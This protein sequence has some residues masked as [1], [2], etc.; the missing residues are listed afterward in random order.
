MDLPRPCLRVVLSPLL[1]KVQESSGYPE[2]YLRPSPW[3]LAHHWREP[4]HTLFLVPGR[5]LAF[6][7]E[8]LHL[9]GTCTVLCPSFSLQLAALRSGTNPQT[10]QAPAPVLD[11]HPFVFLFCKASAGGKRVKGGGPVM[12]LWGMLGN[13]GPR[14]NHLHLILGPACTS[15]RA[16][17]ESS[18][19]LRCPIS[20]LPF[21]CTLTPWMQ[22]ILA[23][24]TCIALSPESHSTPPEMELQR[25]SGE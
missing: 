24:L 2:D 25:G 13:N 16:W 14:L 17:V 11:P 22:P 8:Q 7:L 19:A 10:L 6:M 3:D 12:T 18:S 23:H 5:T 20:A 15:A 4:R 9:A 1:K 21:A